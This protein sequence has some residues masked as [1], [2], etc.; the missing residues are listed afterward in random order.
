MENVDNFVVI[1]GSS[2]LNRA[3][4]ALPLLN[5]KSGIYSNGIYGFLTMYNKIIEKFSPK[6]MAVAF[7]R[8]EK[9]FRNEMYDEYK[10][11]RISF[12]DELKIQFPILRRIL[13]FMGVKDLDMAGY[14][15]DDI[16][17]TLSTLANDK[18]KLILIT[19]DKDYFQ[20]INK[21]VEVL[22][23]KKGV[24]S[25]DIYDIDKLKEVY[26]L[27]PEEF[28]E[29][30]ALMGDSSD[31]IPGI[32]GIG[33]VTGIK[34]INRYKNLENL[35]DNIYDE[36]KSKLKEKIIAGKEIAYLSRDLARIRKDLPISKDPKDYLIGE[37]DTHS[38]IEIYKK[39]EFNSFLDKIDKSSINY[40]E[41]ENIKFEFEDVKLEIIDEVK[42]DNLLKDC[43][44]FIF[45]LYT[46]DDNYLKSELSYISFF[47]DDTI[48]LIKT[49]SL[50]IIKNILEDEN[51]IKIS[52]DFKKNIVIG[53]KNNVTINNYSFDTKIAQYLIDPSKQSYELK[54]IAEIYFD[55]RFYDLND[56]Y[57][58]NKIKNKNLEN[59]PLEKICDFIKNEMY[60]LKNSYKIM[61]EKISETKEEELLYEV[62]QPLSEAL[63]HMEYIG[64][65]VDTQVLTSLKE[66]YLKELE[67]YTSLIYEQA[68]EE[69]NIN[70]TKQLSSILFEKMN[71][72]PIKKTK[73]GYSTDVEVLEILSKDYDICK[74]ILE[75][76]KLSKLISTYI[77]GLLAIIDKKTQRVHSYFNQTNTSTGRISSSDPNLQNI[78]VKTQEGREIR[79]AFVADDGNMLIDSDYSQIEL[80]I[81]AHV[82]DDKKMIDAFNNNEDIHT[83]TASEVFKVD[84]QDVSSIQRSNAKAVNFGIVYG[85]SDYGLSR[86]L[87]ISRKEAKEYIDS[88]FERFKDI[89]KYMTQIVEDAKEKGYVITLFNRRRYIPELK[90][91]NFNIRSFGERI[92]LN[93]PIQGSAADIMKIAIVKV[94]KRI[95]DEKLDADIILTV[96]DEIVIEAKKDI[97]EKI[98][99]IV[100]EEMENVLKLKVDLKVDINCAG[101]WYEAK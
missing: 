33:Q 6:Y 17:G 53:L 40:T 41:K 72:V 67:K 32:S 60:T 43:D 13:Y 50:N 5:T 58:E 42:A 46:S 97:K 19:G 62:E 52:H 4:Y 96:H 21:N 100:R 61:R 84:M 90:S 30:K 82:A 27:T 8:K 89:H 66:E 87:N 14:E 1:D 29:L 47:K 73:T 9:T 95:K 24:S 11:N 80:R 44:E 56:I 22:Y 37:V 91:K 36:P 48:Y 92:A 34:I 63:A 99:N 94:F 76:R 49:D 16:A 28:L 68:Q 20:L 75:Y 39:L 59:L 69:F 83:R 35:Y 93:T 86:D 15:A 3:F 79:K 38:L 85:I 74:Y 77:D 98:I 64:F 26:S 31:N 81:L 65:K 2:L 12:P 57:T 55:R 10:G 71:I 45:N 7:D 88:Y 25:F 23:T 51:I 70:S 78:P 54:N 101:N 18:L